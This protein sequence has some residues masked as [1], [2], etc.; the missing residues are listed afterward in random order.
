LKDFNTVADAAASELAKVFKGTGASSE[1]EIKNWR[2]NLDPN[3]SPAQLKAAIHTAIT[4]LLGSRLDTIRSQYQATMGKPADFTILTP[5]SRAVLKSLGVDP[6][7]LEQGNGAQPG[8]DV[9]AP[10]AVTPAGQ[11]VLGQMLNPQ[12]MGDGWTEMGGGVRIRKVN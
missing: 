2:A 6:S 1:E 10:G 4:D 7:Q 5:H 9:G 11:R 12:P 8:V 3:A